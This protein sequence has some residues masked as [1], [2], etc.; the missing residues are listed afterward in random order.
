ME[1]TQLFSLVK[2][3]RSYRRFDES[4][5]IPETTLTELVELARITPSS[6]N[7]QAIRFVLSREAEKNAR[8]FEHLAWAGALKD[9]P[10][11]AAGERPAGYV[12]LL[13]DTAILKSAQY[14]AGIIAQTLL[15]GAV[16]KGFGGCM[17]GS[18]QREK[19]KEALSIPEKYHIELVVALGKPVEEV[20]LEEIDPG[21]SINYW[22]DDSQVHH[23]PKRKLKD[24]ILPY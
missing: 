1:T 21:D 20:V 2:K 5:E 8:I 10:G 22:R 15:L 9:W 16:E 6:G 11:P 24:L 23:V 3:N 4:F 18:V 13:T 19:L 12:I 14:D 7:R 17:F